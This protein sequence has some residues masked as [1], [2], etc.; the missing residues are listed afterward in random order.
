MKNLDLIAEELFNKIRGRFPSVTIGDSEG[1]VTNKPNESRFYDFDYVEGDRKLGKVSI[2]LNDDAVEVMY[3]SDFVANEDVITREN[4]YDFLKELRQFSKKRMLSFDT[5]NI[6]KSNLDQRDYKF[7]AT[8]RSGDQN[9][10]ESK[11]YGTNKT[12][13]QR[14]GEARI[15]IKHTKPVDTE[16]ATGRI[17]NIGAIFI[18]SPEG[19]RFKYPFKHLNGARAMARHVAEGGKP[20]DD[21]GT[22]ITGLS[23]ELSSL[24]KFKS[25]VGRSSVMAEGLSGYL[26]PVNERLEEIKKTISNLQKESSYKVAFENFEKPVFEEVP[27]DVAENWVD[28]LTIKQF[29]E[30]LKDVFPFVYRL[31]SEATRAKIVSASDLLGEK[32]DGVYR[33]GMEIPQDVDGGILNDDPVHVVRSG[34]TVYSLAKLYGVEVD[35]VI[36]VN[37]LDDKATIRP[38][39]QLIMPGG[40]EQIGASPFTPGA[41][42]GIDPSQNYSPDDLRRLTTGEALED[43]FEEMMG[44]FGDKVNEA[45][46]QDLGDGFQSIDTTVAGQNMKGV[47]DTQSGSTIVLN[48]GIVRS[49]GKYLVIDKSGKIQ[50]T[51]Q[52]GPMTKKALQ[53]AGLDEGNKFTAALAKAKANDD[54]EMEVDGKKIPVTEFIL[55]LYDRETGQFPKGETAVL[56][57]VE[58]DYG[59]QYINPAKAFIEAINA[60]F[61]EFNGY[62]DPELM[63]GADDDYKYQP[64]DDEISDVVRT[65]TPGSKR[66]DIG[67]RKVD[68]KAPIIDIDDMEFF[69]D[70]D[71][72]TDESALQA[73]IGRKKYGKDGMAALA[74]AGREG[75]SEEE[76]GAIKDKYKKESQD[77]MRL[78]GL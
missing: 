52:V 50:S 78:A 59:E 53:A 3:S 57:A 37:G 7:L 2:S 75:A 29:N 41:T 33:A 10:N 72:E 69:L 51:M 28:Q 39:D 42:R 38:G 19:E 16:S 20:F 45:D 6:N 34:D 13:Y 56:T 21:F 11:M 65:L 8:N 43:A 49:P 62:R 67:K 12:S 24:K 22:H 1:K 23:E 17:Q 74:Q 5:R 31:V 32:D 54:D 27:N 48:K 18:E 68:T 15:A 76:L 25:Y 30:E 4:W 73:H 26:L 14:I 61:E 46:G 58:K 35:D 47:L 55:S 77:I 70:D 71:V 40:S 36:E 9:M 66:R 64:F 44:Q 60:K 63:D